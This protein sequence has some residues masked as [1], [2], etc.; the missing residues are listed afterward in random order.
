MKPVSL[1]LGLLAFTVAANGDPWVTYQPPAD[2]ANGRHIVLLSG[3]EEY[4]SE[5]SLPALGKILS[6]RH[7]FKCTVL[8]SQDASGIIDPNNQTNIPGMHLLAGADLVVNQFRFREL[9][10]P[11]M[12]HFVDYL[13]SG[14]P[15][16]VLRTGNHAFNYT[17][18]KTSPYAKYSYSAPGGGFGGMTVGESW[19]YHHGNHGSEATRGLVDGQNRK[20]PILK[21]VKDVFGPS[22][23]YGVNADF[24]ADAKV[25]LWGMTLVGMKP[26]DPPQ[27]NK[28]IMPLAWLRDV[29]TGGDRTSRILCSTIGAAVDLASED[30]RRFVVNACYDLTGLAVPDKAD[31]TPIGEFNPTMFG[32]NKFKRGVPVSSHVLK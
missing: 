30:L 5:E 22:D 7:G 10:D 9:P 25:L 23:V 1:L 6:Q 26:E 31:V 12:K 4:R 13:D 3:D 32:F 28:A 20:H 2:K 29:K 15:M 18:N 14:K 21:S 17:R 19:T 8:F 27:L 24:P 11:D 16:I